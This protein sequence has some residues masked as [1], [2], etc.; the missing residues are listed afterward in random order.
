[1]ELLTGEKAGPSLGEHSIGCLA[2]MVPARIEG[3][4][5]LARGRGSR[6]LAHYVK[7]KHSARVGSMCMPIT[8][9]LTKATT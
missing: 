2:G 4:E 6:N 5:G 8:R 7:M 9:S 3:S 1:M